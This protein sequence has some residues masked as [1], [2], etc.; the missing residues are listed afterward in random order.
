MRS[1]VLPVPAED[2]GDCF[3][4]VTGNTSLQLCQRAL[5]GRARAKG[6]KFA[7]DIQAP[8]RP[9]LGDATLHQ[10]ALVN[11]AANAIKFTDTDPADDTGI[12]T[13]TIRLRALSID[14]DPDSWP[15]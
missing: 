5:A 3:R 2:P 12:G 4:L 6:L 7:I 9:L 13:D 8:P 11:D 15:S 10:Q 1:D 14:E